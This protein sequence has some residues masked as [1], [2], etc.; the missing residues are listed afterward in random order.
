MKI[1]KP[2]DA[3]MPANALPR[4]KSPGVARLVPVRKD[5][6]WEM[7]HPTIYPERVESIP[8]GPAIRTRAPAQSQIAEP[9]PKMEIGNAVARARLIVSAH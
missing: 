5:L 9:K 3:E 8:S 2:R 6:P 7:D 4:K 1:I